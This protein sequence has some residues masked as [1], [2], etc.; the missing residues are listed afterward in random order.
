MVLDPSGGMGTRKGY[1]ERHSEP[2]DHQ[3]TVCQLEN[4]HLYACSRILEFKIK[5]LRC[6]T[7]RGR[8]TR[9]AE[10]FS[11]VRTWKANHPR[12]QGQVPRGYLICHRY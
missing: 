4:T 2:M 5:G 3:I 1:E 11:M 12:E 6:N 7:E 8:R 10:Y 9:K